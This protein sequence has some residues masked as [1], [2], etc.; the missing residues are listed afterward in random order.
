MQK[1][2][3]DYKRKLRDKMSILDFAHISSKFLLKNNKNLNKIRLTQ[4]KK[5]F[6]LG[7]RTATETNDPTKVIFNFSNRELTDS[8]K[9]LLVKG[10]NLSIPPK[11]LNYADFLAPF[12]F[13]YTKL[14]KAHPNG[15]DNSTA[16]PLRAAIKDSAFECFHS[17]DP[18][19][20]QNLTKDKYN[21]LKVLLKDENIIIQKSDKANSGVILNKNDYVKR[22]EELLADKTK[23]KKLNIETGKDYNH[24]HNQELKISETLRSLKKAGSMLSSTYERINPRGTIPSV[25]YGLFKVHKPTVNNIPKLR[26]ILSAI[27][28]PTYK[29]SQYI[30]TLLKPFTTNKF[31]AKDSFAFANDIQSQNA[32]QFMAS[33]DVDSLFTNIPLA[34]TIDICCDLLFRD[35]PVVDGLNKTEFRTILTIAT[36]ESFI[37]FN[38]AYYQQL[39]GVAMGSPLGPTLANIFLGYHEEKWLADCPSEFKPAY[40]R[41][42]VDDIFILLPSAEC[43]PLF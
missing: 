40:Y 9:K 26:P 33:L 42:Y 43:L 4:E 14:L 30:N 39:D 41:R 35:Q 24:I 6:N 7:L 25:L 36:K 13:L 19:V 37:L 18:K 11:S 21:S 5:L 10:L 38:G 20:E 28:S 16:D 31:T 27:N 8:E 2:L 17:Y 1:A 22:M 34:E 32:S 23:L 12:E 15:I 29:L 3:T